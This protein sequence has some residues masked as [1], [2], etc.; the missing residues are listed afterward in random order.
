MPCPTDARWVPILASAEEI[1]PFLE[2]VALLLIVLL[3]IALLIPSGADEV[4]VDPGICVVCRVVAAAAV[5]VLPDAPTA[6]VVVVFSW[7]MDPEG[8]VYSYKHPRA[9]S[10]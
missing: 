10:L 4:D 2:V 5:L 6:D 1:L 9:V 3:V 8:S 7:S